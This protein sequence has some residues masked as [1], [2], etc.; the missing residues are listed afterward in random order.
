[1]KLLERKNTEITILLVDLFPD[2]LAALQS[3]FHAREIEPVVI[4][5]RTTRPDLYYDIDFHWNAM[6]HEH[7]SSKVWEEMTKTQ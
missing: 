2:N 6:G 1:M 3:F 4:S 5:G 7:A